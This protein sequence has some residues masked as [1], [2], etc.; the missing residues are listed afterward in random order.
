LMDEWVPSGG[1]RLI[2]LPYSLN[3]LVGRIVM[4]LAQKELEVFDPIGDKRTIPKF[5]SN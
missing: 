3:G 4:P 5:L 2:R 1:M